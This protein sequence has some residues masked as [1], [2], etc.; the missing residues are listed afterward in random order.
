MP[1]HGVTIN[2]NIVEIQLKNVQFTYPSRPDEPV[3]KVALL[4]IVA[5]A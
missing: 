5:V 2:R 4:Y 3:I 1:Y